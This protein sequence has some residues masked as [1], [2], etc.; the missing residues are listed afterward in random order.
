MKNSRALRGT[1]PRRRFLAVL[2]RLFA[3]HSERTFTQ[4]GQTLGNSYLLFGRV[5]NS[6]F[7]NQA[8]P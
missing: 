8:S 2:R 4:T 1:D 7:R 6:R 3:S 5:C